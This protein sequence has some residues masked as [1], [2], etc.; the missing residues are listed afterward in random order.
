MD[1]THAGWIGNEGR[2]PKFPLE[3]LRNSTTATQSQ[4]EGVCVYRKQVEG[5]AWVVVTFVSDRTCFETG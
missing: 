2:P 1:D 5:A 3:F 4:L